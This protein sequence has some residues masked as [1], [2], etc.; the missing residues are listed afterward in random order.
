MRLP[1]NLKH[2]F[3]L[4][5]PE[6]YYASEHEVIWLHM[7]LSWGYS[8]QGKYDKAYVEAKKSAKPIKQ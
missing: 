5:T 3:Y 4:E 7:L 2:F 8:M 1:V 6:G